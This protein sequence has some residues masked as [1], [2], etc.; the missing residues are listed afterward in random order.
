T[1]AALVAFPRGHALVARLAPAAAVNHAREQ[2][3]WDV[4]EETAG[5]LHVAV[6]PQAA[7]EAV[8]Q[9]EPL[10]S[11]RDAHVGQA[12]LFVHI[13]GV[14]ALQAAAV[15][16]NALFQPDDENDGIL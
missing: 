15:R 12:S 14:A 7:P 16:Q 2:L 4:V 8:D 9:V 5:R 1:P 3:G 10:P 6:T 13:L 11:A